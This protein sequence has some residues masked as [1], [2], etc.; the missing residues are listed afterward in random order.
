M[1]AGWCLALLPLHFVQ[2]FNPWYSA[3][4]RQDGAF[5][6]S[7]AKNS[8]P[9]TCFHSDWKFHQSQPSWV[10]E[11]QPPLRHSSYNIW[12]SAQTHLTF[13]Q[14][15]SILPVLSIPLCSETF[16]Y[17]YN[18][19]SNSY[20]FWTLHP[21]HLS[22][23]YT[24]IT[25]EFKDT[26]PPFYFQCVQL[27]LYSVEFV[28]SAWDPTQSLVLAKQMLAVPPSCIFSLKSWLL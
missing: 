22:F 9:V 25:V 13:I 18:R 21:E 27:S 16:I 7:R 24:T 19:K 15:S 20:Q 11:K 4:H 1:D 10:S 17:N 28:C 23:S 3:A 5:S 8:F 6:F 2:A 12:I 26:S 14:I